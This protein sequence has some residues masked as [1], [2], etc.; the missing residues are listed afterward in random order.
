MKNKLA[1]ATIAISAVVL[2]TIQS[3]KKEEPEKNNSSNDSNIIE[4]NRSGGFHSYAERNVLHFESAESLLSMASSVI[5]MN[6]SERTKWEEHNNFKSF[7]TKCNELIE[8][9]D[10]TNINS[11]HNFVKNN[12]DYFY[13]SVQDNETYLLSYFDESFLRYFLNSYKM[14]SVA[15]RYY[16]IFKEGYIVASEEDKDYLYMIDSFEQ[17]MYV[18][19]LDYYPASRTVYDEEVYESIDGKDKLKVAF[20]I[21]SH[22]IFYN[23]AL[24]NIY[25]YHKTLGIWI[26]CKRTIS[27]NVSAEWTYSYFSNDVHTGSGNFQVDSDKSFGVSYE[28]GFMTSFT[29]LNSGHFTSTSGWADTPSVPTCNF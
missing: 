24:V 22:P 12:S 15:D 29:N 5:R 10:T 16:K 8:T 20:K 17:S 18:N 1:L 19:E 14:I 13:L 7:Y 25:P 21:E 9:M 2:L 28:F 27:A 26:R 11:I 3:C 23:C 4:S 6:D